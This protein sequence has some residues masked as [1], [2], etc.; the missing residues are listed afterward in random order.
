VDVDRP[1]S[2]TAL[3]AERHRA[4][5]QI[6][7]RGAVF[8]DPLAVPVLGET[9]EALLEA[10]RERVAALGEPWITQLAP[11]DLARLLRTCG[12]E[13]THLEDEVGLIRGLLGR[14]PAP[15]RRV[16]HLALATTGWP[17]SPAAAQ[18]ARS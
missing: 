1:A 4:V 13:K 17:G 15:E 6:A 16:T 8:T 7:E 14:P 5:H 3:G 11:D 18:A 2:R 10:R 9:P 12:Y